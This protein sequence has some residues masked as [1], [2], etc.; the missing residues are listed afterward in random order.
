MSE[1]WIYDHEKDFFVIPGY[2]LYPNCNN[3]YAAGGT[4]VYI[5]DSLIDNCEVCSPDLRGS[6]MIK[7]TCTVDGQRFVFMCFYR[8]HDKS[9]DVFVEELSFLLR[10]ESSK[11]VIILGD[12]NLDILL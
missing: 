3:S 5:S 10:D 11:N 12:M 8:L 6:D 2:R 1:I 7:V 4:A 9:K